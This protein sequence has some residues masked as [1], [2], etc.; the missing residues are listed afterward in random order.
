MLRRLA[1]ALALPCAFALASCSG[2]LQAPD[3]RDT[4]GAK[5][6][7]Y[8]VF[9][10][11]MQGRR[12]T[13]LSGSLDLSLERAGDGL[14]LTVAVEDASYTTTVAIDV[15]YDASQVHPVRVEF[16]GLLGDD[17]Q[18]ISAA[19]LTQ[20]PGCAGVG[21]TVVGGYLPGPLN[22]DFAVVY[23]ERTPF[24]SHTVSRAPT[25]AIDV[26]VGALPNS[27]VA[28][29]VVA[30]T[31]SI[32]W[33]AGFNKADGDQNQQVNI[34][35]IT[36]IGQKF[37]KRWSGAGAVW[38]CLPADYD[39]NTEVNLGD[40]TPI[41]QNFQATANTFLV[42]A[43]DDA[44]GATPT[45]V[46]TVTWDSAAPADGTA[47][48]G[49]LAKVFKSWKVDFN[50][51][52]PFTYAQLKALDTNSNNMVNLYVTPQDSASPPVKGATATLTISV[53]P[54]AVTITSIDLSFTGSDTWMKSG[55]DYAVLVTELSADAIAGNGE[56]FPAAPFAPEKIQLVATCESAEDPGVPFDGTGNLIYY[57][58]IGEGLATVGNGGI[59]PKGEV[60]FKDRGIVT[61]SA[62]APGNF[63]IEDSITFRLFSIDSLE[64]ELAAGGGGPVGVNAGQSV[65]FKAIGTFDYDTAENGNEVTQDLTQFCNWGALVNPTTT[66]I[67]FDSGLGSLDTTGA[68]SGAEYKVTCE[69]PKTDNVLIYDNLKRFSN[70]VTVNIN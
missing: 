8:Q 63:L 68:A 15:L 17:S 16:N 66:P 53:A 54:S 13:A 10:Y 31:A 4:G 44:G 21:Q 38:A 64:L 48:D 69:F 61:I 58:S 7:G 51:S 37:M 25:Q 52:S 19:F 26:T 22:G 43:G 3:I 62:H 59:A 2:A 20:S 29:D 45:A 46:S 65:A 47:A 23:F 55:T 11:D 40:I 36:P 30:K 50:A 57:I 5:L 39:A 67:T 56:V 34:A 32:K 6:D 60:A 18:V 42:E 70:F 27:E 14:A 1:L 35:D 41:G 24:S 9:R 33:Y 49:V 28:S 12:N